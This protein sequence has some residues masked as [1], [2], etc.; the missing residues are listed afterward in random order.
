MWSYE[1]YFMQ[2][3]TVCRNTVLL[4]PAIRPSSGSQALGAILCRGSSQAKSVKIPR[5]NL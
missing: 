3:L 1:L 2:G 5:N 4:P